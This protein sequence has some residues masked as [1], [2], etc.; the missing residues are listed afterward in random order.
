MGNLAASAENVATISIDWN[1]KESF[2]LLRIIFENL[3]DGWKET[4]LTAFKDRQFRIDIFKSFSMKM[5]T[6]SCRSN[7]LL[8]A[9]INGGRENH[10][11]GATTLVRLLEFAGAT[12]F[13]L[14]SVSRRIINMEK[15]SG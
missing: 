2:I 12:E 6:N 4:L 14:Q 11:I 5:E 15:N 9:I 3:T 13:N 8:E 10:R 1:K 7:N